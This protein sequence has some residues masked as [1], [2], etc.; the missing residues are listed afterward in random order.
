MSIRK[1]IGKVRNIEEQ[2]RLNDPFY[3]SFSDKANNLTTRLGKVD[4]MTSAA[5]IK[6]VHAV[7]TALDALWYKREETRYRVRRIEA[8]TRQITSRTYNRAVAAGTTGQAGP[9]VRVSLLIDSDEVAFE[10]DAFFQAAMSACDKIAKL[11]YSLLAAKEEAA[12]TRG[13]QHK[14]I[15]AFVTSARSRVTSPTFSKI[16]AAWDSWIHDLKDCRD[17]VEHH[18]RYFTYARNPDMNFPIM[19]PPPSWLEKLTRQQINAFSL[20]ELPMG[21]KELPV[22]C[23][24][25]LEQLQQLVIGILDESSLKAKLRKQP[26]Q[27]KRADS[28]AS[29]Q[30]NVRQLPRTREA[31]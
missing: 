8:L 16:M 1:I 7:E 20:D 4:A 14:S 9:K 30:S 13:L 12:I 31:K 26:G 15:H 27:K 23:K 22:Y 29:G 21:N 11:A 28:R 25:I 2:R 19:V 6:R 18:G 24:R 10:V 17:F 5:H 3:A